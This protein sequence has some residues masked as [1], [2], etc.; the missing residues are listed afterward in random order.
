M[1]HIWACQVFLLHINNIFFWCLCGVPTA[2][3]RLG[4]IMA[5]VYSSLPIP[6]FSLRRKKKSPACKGGV[7]GG[8][9][10]VVKLS[11]ADV[12]FSGYITVTERFSLPSMRRLR[13]YRR[14]CRNRKVRS[15]SRAVPKDPSHGAGSSVRRT[16]SKHRRHR[17][18]P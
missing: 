6:D 15:C 7:R 4:F 16:P 8:F 2:C 9:F 13:R 10:H 11:M 1:R 18:R 5:M 14:C 12:T 3:F 17:H